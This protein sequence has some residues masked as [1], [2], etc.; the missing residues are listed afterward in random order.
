[1]YV[2]PALGMEQNLAPCGC[3]ASDGLTFF[4]QN[5]NA[6]NILNRMELT[7]F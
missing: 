1:M 5:I 7:M 6:K 3:S 4:G 2:I